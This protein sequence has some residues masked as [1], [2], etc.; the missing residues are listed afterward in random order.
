MCSGFLSSPSSFPIEIKM[1]LL[2]SIFKYTFFGNVISHKCLKCAEIVELRNGHSENDVR[3]KV[4]G[5]ERRSE[6]PIDER[7]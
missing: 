1:R 2:K 4:V 3:L 5:K 6:M 7:I